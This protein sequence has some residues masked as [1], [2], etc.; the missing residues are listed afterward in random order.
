MDC[1]AIRALRPKKPF[2][3]NAGIIDLYPAAD[4]RGV[5]LEP[6]RSPARYLDRGRATC[7]VEPD[8]R[9]RPLE[10]V[11]LGV[12]TPARPRQKSVGERLSARR[13]VL[14]PEGLAATVAAVRAEGLLFPSSCP[15]AARSP[16]EPE[17]A[18]LLSLCHLSVLSSSQAPYEPALQKGFSNSTIRV[19]FGSK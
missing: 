1:E 19:R 5:G 12:H 2:S 14:A 16:R 10:V 8:R 13:R 7:R 18:P 11:L 17:T 6:G 15:I 9:H 3:Q 4:H